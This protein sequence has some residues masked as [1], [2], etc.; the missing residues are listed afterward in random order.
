MVAGEI[1]CTYYVKSRDDPQGLQDVA[2]LA[3]DKN[4]DKKKDD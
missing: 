3:D 1:A 2:E 4:D